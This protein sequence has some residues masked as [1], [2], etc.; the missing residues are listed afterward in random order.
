LQIK[1]EV[2][3]GRKEDRNASELKCW[4]ARY[5]KG[6]GIANGPLRPG[7]KNVDGGEGKDLGNVHRGGEDQRI[8]RASQSH[9]GETRPLP[10]N[11][12]L[13]KPLRKEGMKQRGV[14]S[15]LKARPL[16]WEQS[17]G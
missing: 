5:R 4:V 11:E 6:G 10:V 3:W 7:A 15:V 14:E 17:A 9:N 2:D 16:M 1:Q 13:P 12:M 8:D